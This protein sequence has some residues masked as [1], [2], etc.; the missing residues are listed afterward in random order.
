MQFMH[1]WNVNYNLK[2]VCFICLTFNHLQ[3]GAISSPLLRGRFCKA[4]V[5]RAALTDRWRAEPEHLASPGDP[6]F[7]KLK[8]RPKAVMNKDERDELCSHICNLLTLWTG[9]RLELLTRSLVRFLIL[10]CCSLWRWSFSWRSWARTSF[11][12]AVVC[13]TEETC[14]R[15][16]V[17]PDPWLEEAAITEHAQTDQ[18]KSPSP[19]EVVSWGLLF[20]CDIFWAEH[21]RHTL[22]WHEDHSSFFLLCWRTDRLTHIL[23]KLNGHRHLQWITD[24][25]NTFKCVAEQTLFN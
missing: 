3:T 16:E 2:H 4:E 25:N 1:V 18:E 8:T 17:T 24:L 15:E 19:H 12:V 13:V 23:I 14:S 20:G 22:L 11:S 21:R 10:S 6:S 7:G 5:G 9:S